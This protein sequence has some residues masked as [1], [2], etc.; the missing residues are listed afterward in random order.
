M[1]KAT[2]NLKMETEAIKKIQ[3]ERILEME[4]LGK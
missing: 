4:N 2:Q 1:S 3:I